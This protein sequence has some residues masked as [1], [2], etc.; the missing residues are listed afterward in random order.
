MS[1]Y[2]YVAFRAIDGPVSESDLKFME[3]QSSRA[4]I[5]PWSFENEYQYGDFRGDAAAMLRRGYDFHFHYANFGVRKLMIRLPNGLPDPKAAT[6]Y[7]DG[8]GLQF[9]KDKNG[10]GG[11]LCIE[12]FFESGELED[13]WEFDGVLDRLLPLRAEI[14]GGDL[15]PLYLAHLAVASDSN[16]NPEEGKEGAVPAGLGK[17]TDAQDALAELY[18][19]SEALIA[20]AARNAPALPARSDAQ[21]QYDEWIQRQPEAAKNGWLAQLMADP[22]SAVRRE[23]L[24]EFQKTERS[25]SWSTTPPDRTV[26][27]LHAAAEEIQ[28]E[29]DRKNAEKAARQRAKKLSEMAAD[30]TRTLRKTEEL[31]KQR[32]TA[33]YRETATLLGD[34]REAL[35]GGEEPDLPEKHARKL[36]AKHPT[37]KML[38]SELRR[39]GFLKK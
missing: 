7:L 15:R 18:G 22:H 3:K 33:S 21:N 13:L 32:S 2:Q 20:A 25:P 11:I 4:E 38:A 10:P 26:A 35:E 27:D 36:T 17:L 1:E 34:L 16:H 37:L 29:L 6:P 5:T 31:V 9:A 23:I 8:E 24:A 19:L 30:P 28:Q 14:L 12:P 39:K